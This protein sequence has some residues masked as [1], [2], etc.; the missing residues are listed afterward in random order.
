M[1]DAEVV[2]SGVSKKDVIHSGLVLNVKGVVRAIKSGLSYVAISM[3]A[4]DTHS[5]KNANKSIE[6]SSIE[7]ARISGYVY[8]WTFG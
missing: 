8:K 7:F 2:F 3:S 4:S 5:R 6:D 1:A